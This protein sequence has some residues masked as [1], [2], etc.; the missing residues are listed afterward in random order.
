M[1][2]FVI[3]V[4]LIVGSWGL[5]VGLAMCASE[6]LAQVPEAVQKEALDGIKQGGFEGM[7]WLAAGVAAVLGFAVAWLVKK[8]VDHLQAASAVALEQAKADVVTGREL[9]DIKNGLRAKGVIP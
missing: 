8:F 6:A 7:F 9:T 4:C 5:A 2:R 3:W 1:K